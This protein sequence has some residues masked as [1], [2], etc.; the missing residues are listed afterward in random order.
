MRK[1]ILA[2]ICKLVSEWV[3]I[4]WFFGFIHGLDLNVKDD[5]PHI[6]VVCVD[7]SVLREMFQGIVVFTLQPIL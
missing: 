3:R 5:V 1:K 2:S 4:R 7:L 6:T